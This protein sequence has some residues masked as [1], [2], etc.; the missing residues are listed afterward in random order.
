MKAQVKI[1][2]LFVVTFILNQSYAVESFDTTKFLNEKHEYLVQITDKNHINGIS[3]A[4]FTGDKVIW[5]ECYGKS[6]YKKQINDSTLFSI[7]SMSKNFTAL[8]VMFLVQDGLVNLDTPIKKYL[9]DFRIK[10]CYEESL[11]EKI[12]LRMMLNHTA[13]FTHEAPIGNNYD[14]QCKSKQEHWNSIYDTWLKFPVNIRYSY[15]NLGYD[16]AVKIIEKVSGMSFETYI[17]KKIFTPL[18]MKYSTIDDNDVLSNKNK[19]EG[20]LDFFMKKKHYKIPLIG[21]GA[22]YS[23]IDDMIKYVQF[24]MNFGNLNGKQ[25]IER[26]YLM[27]MYTINKNNYGLG[28]YI[29]KSENKENHFDTYFFNHNGGGFG[30]GS[31]MTW[32]P[33]YG[34]G[35]VI[36]GNKP[37][38]YGNLTY[39]LLFEF[40][41]KNECVKKN[42]NVTEGFTPV[43]KPNE[44]DNQKL[45]FLNTNN[46]S[47]N[48]IGSTNIV[49]KYEVVFNRKDIKWYFKILQFFGIKFMT[50]SITV[51]QNIAILEGCFGKYELKEYLPGLFFTN[52]GEVFDFRNE[53]PTFRN[54]KLRKYAEK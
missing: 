8:A 49:G 41:T 50:L 51:S 17:R 19:T 35:C 36:L 25:V 5:K 29:G 40:M 16:L 10:S 48:K 43:F 39:N 6:T 1:I 23:D 24:Q 47:K 54:I 42:T 38:D 20:T 37:F 13:G 18:G 27:D 11:E 22:V 44:Q 14:P 2:L 45:E 26:K 28:T 3:I 12:T 32:F 33:E 7:Q 53:S 9:P 34:L 21:S 46:E 52:D 31:S 15:S 4:F 30:Y